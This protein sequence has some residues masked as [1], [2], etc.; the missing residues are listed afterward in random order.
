MTFRGRQYV[1]DVFVGF[2]VGVFGFYMFTGC[3]TPE[4]LCRLY[5]CQSASSIWVTSQF[6]GNYPFECGKKKINT[7]THASS[8][9]YITKELF[10]HEPNTSL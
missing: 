8:S 9:E 7:Q 4:L 2:Y 6:W 10:E 1:F 3:G 5:L